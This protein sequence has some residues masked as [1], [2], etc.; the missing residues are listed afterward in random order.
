MIQHIRETGQE[1]LLAMQG[2]DDSPS[3]LTS[4]PTSGEVLAYQTEDPS[5][6]PM[7]GL[8]WSVHD[9]SQR[10]CRVKSATYCT[11]TTVKDEP[12]LFYCEPQRIQTTAPGVHDEHEGYKRGKVISD[13]A[14]GGYWNSALRGV[15]FRAWM[16]RHVSGETVWTGGVIGWRLSAT[17]IPTYHAPVA[18]RTGVKDIIIGSGIDTPDQLTEY[19]PDFYAQGVKFVSQSATET[20][21]RAVHVPGSKRHL[22]VS[23]NYGQRFHNHNGFCQFMNTQLGPPNVDGI[24]GP[25][26]ARAELLRWFHDEPDLDPW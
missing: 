25:D 4:E 26:E 6:P 21:R 7:P 14:T 8:V 24:I 20:Y 19:N 12:M 3:F 16:R 22:L 13:L 18:P 5:L 15:C 11:V 9:Q 23:M 1:V 17:S 10:E 2:F